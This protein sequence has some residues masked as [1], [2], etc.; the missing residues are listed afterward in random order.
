MITKV[1]GLGNLL[2]GDD[3]VGVHVVNELQKKQL[4]VNV[5]VIDGGSCGLGLLTLMEGADRVIIIDAMVSAGKPGSLVKLDPQ[6]FKLRE[7]QKAPSS[8]YLSLL[9]TLE[10]AAALGYQQEVLIV[11]ITPETLRLSTSLSSRLQVALPKII[12]DILEEL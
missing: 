12:E 1:I 6:Q 2:V 11:G 9:Q 4:P 10:L 3:G 7:P 5:E 8:H